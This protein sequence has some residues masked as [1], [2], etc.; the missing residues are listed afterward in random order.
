MTTATA[1]TTAANP[2]KTA[3]SRMT[4]M[5]GSSF[6]F[7]DTRRTPR[8]DTQVGKRIRQVAA[9]AAIALGLD[10]A[11]AAEMGLQVAKTGV[12]DDAKAREMV[13]ET[14]RMLNS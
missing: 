5:S 8:E 14:A 3:R 2:S 11:T 13:A 4:R 9:D 1:R 12:T 6:T 10:A 7:A